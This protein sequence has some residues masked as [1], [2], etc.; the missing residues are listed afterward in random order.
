M[1]DPILHIKDSYYFEVPR[2]LWRADYDSLDEVPKFLRDAHPHES[3]EAF[4][5]AMDGKILIPQPFGELKNL[6]EGKSGFLISKFMII[7]VVVA[8]GLVLLFAYIARRMKGGGLPKGRVW[9]LFESMLVYIKEDVAHAAIGHGYEKFVP[10]LWTLFFFIMTM[11]LFGLLP[12]VGTATGA[13]GVTLTLG[14][15]V[16]I[17]GMIEGSKQLGPVGYW[18]NYLPPMELPAIMFPVKIMVW[19]IEVGGTIIKHGVLGLRLLAN[20]MAGHLILFS[21]LGLIVMAAAASDFTWGSVTVLAVLGSTA[22]LVLELGFCMVQAFVF[23]F[24]S[25]LFLGA[26]THHH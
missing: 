3:L 17:Y 11:N 6:Y 20:M 25:A 19:V 13:F 10:L 15:F 4:N 9:N 22:F 21:L 1:A 24:L 5:D 23:T 7:E 18:K 2:A 26:A 8:L 16:F 12:W 14:A